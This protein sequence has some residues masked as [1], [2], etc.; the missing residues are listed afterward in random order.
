MT[1]QN[2]ELAQQDDGFN[3]VIMMPDID[4]DI[5]LPKN[6]SEAMPDLSVAEEIN[7][8]A[9]TIKLISDLKG[10]NIEIGRAHV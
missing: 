2:F 6:A 9:N 10:D 4:E 5:P 7:M 8:R 3:H 1:D